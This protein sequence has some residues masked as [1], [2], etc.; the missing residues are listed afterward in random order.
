MIPGFE[1]MLAA[2]VKDVSQLKYPMYASAKLDGIRAVIIDGVVYSRNLKPIPNKHVQK[3]FGKKKYN[4]LDGELLLENSAILPQDIFRHTSS[5]VM[6]EDGKPNVKFYV[7]DEFV[8]GLDY[9]ERRLDSRSGMFEMPSIVA[10]AQITVESEA[11]LKD[12]EE[13]FLANGYEGTML[14][15]CNSGAYKFGRSTLKEGKLMKLK[16]FS[17]SEAEIIGWEE[18]MHNGNAAETDNLGRTKRSSHKANKTG[19]GTLGALIVKDL[20]TGVEFNIGTGFDDELRAEL[21]KMTKNVHAHGPFHGMV[22]K[23]KY[24]P[25]GSKEKPRFPVF[26]GFRDLI[27]M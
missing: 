27:D 15:N 24:F 9:S 13:M 5:A 12:A 16:R 3:L 19:K 11:E 21:W 22:V 10:V 18:Q 4:G 26:I 20:K 14:R 1:P 2:T 7:F 6:S 23:Y 17:D 8:S 25:T